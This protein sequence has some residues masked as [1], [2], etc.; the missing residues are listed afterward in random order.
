MAEPAIQ[1]HSSAPAQRYGKLIAIIDRSEKV[2]RLRVISLDVDAEN[3][4]CLPAIY[5]SLEARNL[6][7]DMVKALGN[8]LSVDLNRLLVI[9]VAIQIRGKLYLYAQLRPLSP[10]HEVRL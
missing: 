3:K 7:G 8:C 2:P 10:M 6:L 4:A 1:L 9:G 5:D